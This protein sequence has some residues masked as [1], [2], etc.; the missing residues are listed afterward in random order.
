MADHRQHDLLRGFQTA[1]AKNLY[2]C[3]NKK[4]RAS[5]TKLLN[6]FHGELMIN[7]WH[8]KKIMY[9]KAINVTRALVHSRRHRTWVGNWLREGSASCNV[10]E[11]ESFSDRLIARFESWLWTR[12]E[13]GAR[14]W[15]CFVARLGVCLS[16]LLLLGLFYIFLKQFSPQHVY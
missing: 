11:G 15:A 7:I 2:W 9:N 6:N 5:Y 12:R 3:G 1:I 13:N 10:F 16:S 4:I 14:L 8:W